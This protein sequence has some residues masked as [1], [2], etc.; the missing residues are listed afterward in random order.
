MVGLIS[1]PRSK[2]TIE[3]L[4]AGITDENI[5]PAVDWEPNVGKEILPSELF[6]STGDAT[7]PQ[8]RG[9]GII[10]H[11]CD[12]IGQWGKGFVLPLGKRYPDAEK[13]YRKWYARKLDPPICAG[14]GTICS[15]RAGI[16]GCQYDRA[17]WHLP[18]QCTAAGSV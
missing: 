10:A 15:S 12:D 9:P 13:Q 18:A 17:A 1:M 11:V 2:Y 5:H 6:Y 8:G 7:L 14:S 4:L 16:M 3:E